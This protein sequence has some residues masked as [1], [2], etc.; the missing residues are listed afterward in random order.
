MPTVQELRAA[1]AAAEAAEAAPV[2]PAPASVP[3]EPAVAASSPE[4][5]ASATPAPSSPAPEGTDVPPSPATDAAAVVAAVEHPDSQTVETAAVDVAQ[6]ALDA[7]AAE[8]TAHPERSF[9]EHLKELAEKGLAAAVNPA[10]ESAT[11]RVVVQ[12]L[13]EVIA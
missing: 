3:D 10:D 9:G 7:L 6:T 12:I 4:V 5:D 8:K 13:K 2:T 1:L 11:L